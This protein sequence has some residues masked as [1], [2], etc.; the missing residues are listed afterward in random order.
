MARRIAFAAV[1][2]GL[3]LVWGY[4]VVRLGQGDLLPGVA[5]TAGAG[6]LFMGWVWAYQRATRANEEAPSFW[7]ALWEGTLTFPPYT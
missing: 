4:G 5:L 1:V 7:R 3:A 2:L 6:F